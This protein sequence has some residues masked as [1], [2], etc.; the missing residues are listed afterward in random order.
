MLVLLT[1]QGRLLSGPVVNVPVVFV[2]EE[3]V[4]LELFGGHGLEVGLGEGGED[5]VG[6]E[7]AAFAGLVCL[8]FWYD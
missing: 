8:F 3:V 6:F 5:E 7:G 2:E 4:L 1:R